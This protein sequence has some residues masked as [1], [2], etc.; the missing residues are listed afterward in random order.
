MQ[1]QIVILLSLMFLAS[2]GG[3][4]P[5]TPSDN[6][7]ENLVGTWAF[8]ST[9]MVDVMVLAIT[10]YM[11]GAGFD[12]S[13]IDEINTELR[14]S[15]EDIPV[16][17]WTLR[18]NADGSF[19]DD[20]GSRGT[21]RVEGNTLI[22]VEDGDEERFKYFV[23]GDNLTLIYPFEFVLDSMREDDNYSDEL[24]ALLSDVF[25]EDVNIRLFFKRR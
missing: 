15:L 8:D 23:D 9:D 5:V 11:I 3:D 14:P 7:D 18:L 17:R 20:Q 6:L 25:D 16:P 21:W 22:T 1:R 13:D 2:C 4:N 19:E 24:I 10:E 12:Q